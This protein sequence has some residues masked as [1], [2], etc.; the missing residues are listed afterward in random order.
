MK[1]FHD[2]VEYEV[3][4]SLEGYPDAIMY[5]FIGDTITDIVKNPKTHTLTL[6]DNYNRL[7]SEGEITRYRNKF[8]ILKNGEWRV[9]EV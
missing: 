7:F 3:K 5:H 2:L 4:N 8:Y 9:F 1:M 6:L